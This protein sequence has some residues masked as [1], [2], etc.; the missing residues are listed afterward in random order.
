MSL[1]DDATLT[2]DDIFNEARRL[3]LNED[4]VSVATLARN[5]ALWAVVNWLFLEIELAEGHLASGRLALTLQ[6]AMIEKPE[7]DDDDEG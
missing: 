2:D 1:I 5:K 4:E 7:A 6:A 3:W